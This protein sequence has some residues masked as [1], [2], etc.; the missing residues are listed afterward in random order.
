VPEYQW[1]KASGD[2]ADEPIRHFNCDALLL[3]EGQ[4]ILLYSVEILAGDIG[5]A[6]VKHRD[7]V[8]IGNPHD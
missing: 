5:A 4:H 1:S 7:D 8:A 3:K 2:G 6:Q